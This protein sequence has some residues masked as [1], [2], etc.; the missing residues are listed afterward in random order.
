MKHYPE[1][2]DGRELG[3][4]LQPDLAFPEMTVKTNYSSTTIKRSRP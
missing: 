1:K 2:P 3:T 4:S